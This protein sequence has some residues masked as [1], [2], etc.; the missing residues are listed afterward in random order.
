[1]TS[2]LVLTQTAAPALVGVVLLGDRV[3]PGWVPLAVLGMALSLAGTAVLAR[4]E[5]VHWT[6][7]P[8]ATDPPLG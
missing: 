7:R 1:V 2:A 4:F 5:R 6:P 8:L 3:R